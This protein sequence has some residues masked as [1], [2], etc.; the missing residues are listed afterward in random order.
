V[1]LTLQRKVFPYH[2]EVADMKL[3]DED[4]AYTSNN[5]SLTAEHHNN[6]PPNRCNNQVPLLE[7]RSYSGS[8]AAYRRNKSAIWNATTMKPL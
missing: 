5:Y 2:C 8:S 7:A 6:H 1:L 3:V 4:F